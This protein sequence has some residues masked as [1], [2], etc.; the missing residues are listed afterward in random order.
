M[1][2]RS[3]SLVHYS[4]NEFSKHGGDR[5]GNKDGWGIVF[6]QERDAYWFK[7]PDPASDSALV[8]MVACMNRSSRYVMAHVR[9]ASKGDPSLENTHPFRRIRHGKVHHFAHNGTL[10]GYIERHTG[11][12]LARQCLGDTDSEL[13]FMDLLDRLDKLGAGESDVPALDDRFDV[14]TEFAAEMARHGAAN[15]LYCDGDALF[16]HAHR[17]RY[18]TAH[19]LSEP[20]APGLHVRF[21]MKTGEEGRWSASGAD[22]KDLD[23]ETILFASV[24][25]NETGWEPLPEGCAFLVKHG[26]EIKRRRTI[27]AGA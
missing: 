16:V 9:R 26:R 11:G 8:D 20:R 21:C 18:E 22:I 2:S 10:E 23:P 19:G 27:K 6:F 12:R 5:Y 17:R 24:P 25:L 4:L 15:F 13:A 7:E 1:S 3:P 14:F